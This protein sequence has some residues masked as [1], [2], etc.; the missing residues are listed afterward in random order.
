MRA[1]RGCSDF[2]E[3]V[4]ERPPDSLERAHSSRSIAQPSVPPRL[5]LFFLYHLVAPDAPYINSSYGETHAPAS[6]PGW[7]GN[8]HRRQTRQRFSNCRHRPRR[9]QSQLNCPK[10][11]LFAHKS[12]SMET[13]QT[14]RHTVKA[15]FVLEI[16][17]PTACACVCVCMQARG[18]G[19]QVMTTVHVFLTVGRGQ[20][21]QQAVSHEE[22]PR[23][24]H[25]PWSSCPQRALF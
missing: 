25:H 16:S 14:A 22:K 15:S 12:K 20:K 23:G 1:L 17:I 10:Q 8:Q 24:F 9:S 4:S 11:H 18:R 2:T 6:R 13:Y 19:R 3:T 21:V 7:A 5:S